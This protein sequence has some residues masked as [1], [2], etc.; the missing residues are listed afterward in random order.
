LHFD[1]VAVSEANQYSVKPS[2]L[3]RT[4]TPPIVAVFRAVPDELALAEGPEEAPAGE[5][6]EVA[7]LVDELLHAAASSATAAIP[8]EN[9]IVVRIGRFRS[10]RNL[11]NL[12]DTSCYVTQ[13]GL[14]WPGPRVLPDHGPDS[15]AAEN[16]QRWGAGSRRPHRSPDLLEMGAANALAVYPQL[17]WGPLDGDGSSSEAVER[18]AAELAR[19]VSRLA[20]ADR[21]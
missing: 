7:G 17:G 14:A 18:Y 5:L 10:K 16:G 3:V 4:V 21:G 1:V 6:L 20:P 19:V 11:R 15:L 12:R 9:R 13:R 8:M 2:A